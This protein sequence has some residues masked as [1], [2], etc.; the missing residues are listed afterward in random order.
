MSAHVLLNLFHELGKSRKLRGLL[1]ILS[2]FH[3]FNTIIEEHKMF[4]SIYHM[5]L[6]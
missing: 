2:L 6:K 1:S 4:D 5:T 3:E